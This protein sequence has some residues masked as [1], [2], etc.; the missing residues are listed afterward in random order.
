[1]KN[2]FNFF[3][4]EINEAFQYNYFDS[5]YPI[6]DDEYGDFA[7]ESEINLTEDEIDE[8]NPFFD[9]IPNYRK[10]GNRKKRKLKK[11][12]HKHIYDIEVLL[13]SKSEYYDCGFKYYH[14]TNF[15]TCGLSGY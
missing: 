3:K 2:T 13:K 11:S 9:E 12:N 10:R 6:F 15:S 5:F 1:M 4:C 7:E 14:A 8:L